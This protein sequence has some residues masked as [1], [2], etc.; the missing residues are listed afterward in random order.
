[1]TTTLPV[2]VNRPVVLVLCHGMTASSLFWL[3]QSGRGC[4]ANGRF[5]HVVGI[6]PES[7][8]TNIHNWNVAFR[9][10]DGSRKSIYLKTV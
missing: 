10:Q 1:M 7:G 5:G 8:S 3:M 6:S 9:F 2:Y 4:K